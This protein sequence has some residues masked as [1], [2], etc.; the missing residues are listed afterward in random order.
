MIQSL[1][2]FFGMSQSATLACFI[3]FLVIAL[4]SGIA[5]S[6]FIAKEVKRR[7]SEK[8]CVSDA[9]EEQ[10][11]QPEQPEQTEQQPEQ[12]PEQQEQQPYEEEQDEIVATEDY[13]PA[14]EQDEDEEDNDEALTTVSDETSGFDAPIIV[15][16]AEGG[17]ITL[18]YNRSFTAKLIMASDV[19][20]NYYSEVKNELLRYG[21]RSR[22]SWRHETFRKG[23]KLLAKMTIRGKTLYLYLALDPKEYAGTKYKI[24]DASSVSVNASVPTLFRI[25]NDRRCRYAK[26]LIAVLMER[27]G[28]VAGSEQ[29][30]DYAAQYPYEDLQALI[31]KNLVTYTEYVA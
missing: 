24:R 3:I 19:L 22:M 29:K 27:E 14:E 28:L 5:D 7:K 15:T 17:K 2:N 8:A 1:M 9:A 26:Q 4:G 30:T 6:V 11:E 12:Q 23:R 25:K 21:V 31:D 16:T 20:K 18:R 13:V 10:S